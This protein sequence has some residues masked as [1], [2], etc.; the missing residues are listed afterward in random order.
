MGYLQDMPA[1]IIKDILEYLHGLD[2]LSTFSLIRTCRLCRDVGVDYLIPADTKLTL[3]QRFRVGGCHCGCDA[4]TIEDKTVTCRD[5]SLNGQLYKLIMDKERSA[6][7]N[8]KGGED[9]MAYVRSR[10][11]DVL[12]KHRYANLGSRIKAIAGLKSTTWYGGNL[13]ILTSVLSKL[14]RVIGYDFDERVWKI[15]APL[16]TIR[17][18]DEDDWRREMEDQ[19]DMNMTVDT[20]E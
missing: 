10:Y 15:V 14:R 2:Y 11:L 4:R 3:T 12:C 18:E 19:L 1:E 9:Y 16:E 13:D 7:I 6:R 5:N 8:L 20:A 17:D